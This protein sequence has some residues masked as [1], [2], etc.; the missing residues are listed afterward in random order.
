MAGKW[1]DWKYLVLVCGAIVVVGW[2]VAS[3]WRTINTVPAVEI[4]KPKMPSPNAYSYYSKAG[5]AMR[6]GREI[7]L[8]V[9]AGTPAANRTSDRAYSLAEKE[10]LV[11]ANSAAL[12]TLRQ[13]FRHR[14][15]APPTR[16]ITDERPE[17]VWFRRLAE[18]LVLEGQVKEGRDDWGGAAESYMD[19]MRM[20]ADL[21]RGA[22]LMGRYQGANRQSRGRLAMWSVVDRLDAQQARAAARRMEDII[23]RRV[24]PADTL[25]EE[26][27]FGEAALMEMFQGKLKDKTGRL[28][29]RMPDYQK[30]RAI[31]VYSRQV[32]RAIADVRL[33]Y[34][35]STVRTIDFRPSRNPFTRLPEVLAAILLPVYHGPFRFAY[36]D[37]QNA[38]LTVSLALRA[39]YLEHR[40]YPA[41]LA[42]LAP[43]YLKRIPDDPFALAGPPRYR[44]AG[45]T[46]LLYSIGPNSKDDGGT[47]VYPAPKVRRPVP[48]A[49]YYV[50]VD[51]KGDI[52]AGVNIQ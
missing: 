7:E 18:L 49:P 25:Q 6:R 45:A 39:Y 26:K 50:E 23:A 38:L 43:S 22:A 32:D 4:P 13:G 28:V 14:C 17:Y 3:S 36:H 40:A 15:L 47:P 20:G 16:S 21:M 8:V 37:A 19:A 51:S 35:K 24:P 44:R 29:G 31:E 27:W 10:A 46:Y 1:E 2:A 48:K 5:Q 52:V 34:P 41:S 30:R 33:P 42:G 12:A 11:K 9:R